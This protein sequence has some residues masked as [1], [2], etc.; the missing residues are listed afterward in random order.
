MTRDKRAVRA[1]P[2]TQGDGTKPARVAAASSLPSMANISQL[3][4]EALEFIRELIRFPSV[5]TGRPETIGDEEAKAARWVEARLREAGYEPEYVEARPGRG[6]VVARLAG[7]DP[8]AGALVVHAHLDV[9]P[10]DGQEWTYPPFGAEIHDG[11]LYGRGAVDVKN[12]AGTLLA[13]ARA[14]RREG[15]TPRRDII[16]AFFA[17]EEAGGAAGA[18]W[19]VRHRPELLAGATEAIGEVGGYSIPIGVDAEGE[20]RR[21]Y[22][23]ATTEKGTATAILTARGTGAHGSRPRADNA[24]VRLARAIAAIGAHRFPVV[25]TEASAEL[26][27]LLEELH[28]IPLEDERFTPEHLGFPAAIVHAATHN[29]AVPTV[30]LAGEKTNV[31]PAVAS[32]K[33]DL[34]VLPGRDEEF[35][36][37]LRSIVPDDVELTFGA[38]YSATEAPLD[39]PLLGVLQEAIT[40]EDA[41]GLVVPYLLPASTDHKHLKALGIRGYGFIPLRVP[42]DFDVFGEFHTADERIPVDALHFST[43]VTWRILQHA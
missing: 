17:D 31:I 10:V 37:E 20:R 1:G 30:L 23:V 25:R 33:L 22:L 32:A 39:T 36:E 11:V 21:G 18:R 41:T 35:K 24:V 15:I 19:I 6:S 7:A 14:F 13:I 42:D 9:V 29:T 5:N 3:E 4:A 26:V 40:A 43:R 34:R 38:W 27:R 8:D 28:G 12:F 2:V 16:F